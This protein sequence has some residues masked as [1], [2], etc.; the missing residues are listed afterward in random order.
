VAV[1]A[2]ADAVGGAVGEQSQRD[3][4]RRGGRRGRPSSGRHLGWPVR[5]ATAAT[6]RSAACT[7]RPGTPG[8]RRRGPGGSRA[9][10]PMRLPGCCGPVPASAG[11]RRC[12]RRSRRPGARRSASAGAVP[13]RR[14]SVHGSHQF[15]LASTRHGAGLRGLRRLL[16]RSTCGGD[17]IS[18]YAKKSCAMLYEIGTAAMTNAQIAVGRR[19]AM[20]ITV[21]TSSDSAR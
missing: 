9:P 16:Q 18:T 17:Q 19:R 15:S 11:V 5:P 8:G 14:P 7:R 20:R 6:D 2:R 10:P 1:A 3:R 21:T 13:R 12:G 4:R